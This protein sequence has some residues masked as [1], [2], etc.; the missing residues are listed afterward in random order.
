VNASQHSW[1]A[2]RRNRRGALGRVHGAPIAS[3]T[4]QRSPRRMR[5]HRRATSPRPHGAA[6]GEPGPCLSFCLIHPRP[7][8]FTGG[9]PARIRAVHVLWRP[10]VDGASQSSKACEGPP[11]ATRTQG[12]ATAPRRTALIT[13]AWKDPSAV[14]RPTLRWRWLWPGQ[15][16]CDAP[17]VWVIEGTRAGNPVVDGR[18][19]AVP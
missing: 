18:T 7:Q 14:T 10:V 1:K 11:A 17:I 12:A 13:C 9:H 19:R 5:A 4:R 3:T 15:W 16:C 2:C 8:P 6:H